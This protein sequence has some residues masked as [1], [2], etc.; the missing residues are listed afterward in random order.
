MRASDGRP[1]TESTL[2]RRLTTDQIL[3][4]EH[5]VAGWAAA[6]WEQRGRPASLLQSEVVGLDRAQAQ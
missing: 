2:D 1:I 6:R 3:D 5:R 4:E